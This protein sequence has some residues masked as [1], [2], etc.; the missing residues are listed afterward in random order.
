MAKK[1]DNTFSKP[2][3]FVDEESEPEVKA[4]ES[5]S[6][7]EYETACK[8]V[9]ICA[10][11]IQKKL[12]SLYRDWVVFEAAT[13]QAYKKMPQTDAMFSDSPLSPMRTLGAL[14]QNMA[15][16]GWKWAAGLPYG[17]ENVKTFLSVVEEAIT[18]G[19]RILKD[20]ERAEKIEAAKIIAKQAQENLQKII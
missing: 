17:P 20:K 9:K 15:K 2:R 1:P 3:R 6:W 13:L 10:T 16:L 12:E 7:S 8:A 11:D 5:K 4:P 19:Q 14:R 18:W